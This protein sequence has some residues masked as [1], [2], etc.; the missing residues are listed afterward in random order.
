M[1]GRKQTIQKLKK[2]EGWPPPPPLTEMS[3][4]WHLFLQLTWSFYGHWAS[5]SQPIDIIICVFNFTNLARFNLLVDKDADGGE[6]LGLP[7]VPVGYPA[8]LGHLHGV[9]LLLKLDKQ[10][11]EKRFKLFFVFVCKRYFFSRRVFIFIYL[12]WKSNSYISV[13]Q[14]SLA[15][16]KITYLARWLFHWPIFQIP[17]KLR[18]L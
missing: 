11:Y 6:A 1:C 12:S 18:F 14:K 9:T 10:N 16:Q 5:V 2:K 13:L 8:L 7:E 17:S 3:F 4:T 15:G